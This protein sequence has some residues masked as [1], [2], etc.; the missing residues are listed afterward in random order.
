MVLLEAQANALPLLTTANCA[1]PDLV[2]SGRNGWILPIR[3][4]DAFVARLR[5]ADEN[6]AELADMVRYIHRNC[7]LRTWDQVASDFE[8]VVAS[9]NKTVPQV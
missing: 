4:P 2:S 8:D 7:Q 3:D 5:W 6:R 9:L 1:G